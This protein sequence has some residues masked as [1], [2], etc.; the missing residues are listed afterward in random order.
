MNRDEATRIAAAINALRPDWA[1][2]GIFK[3]LEHEYLHPRSFESATRALVEVAL[4]PRSVKPTRVLEAGPWWDATRPRDQS[5][6]T[7][8]RRPASDDC[9]ICNHPP[10]KHGANSLMDHEYRPRHSSGR[11]VKA[12]PELVSPTPSPGAPAPAGPDRKA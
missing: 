10:A 11:G 2:A 8:I 3:L 5:T 1:R 4:D 6:S 7:S 9:D 12:P